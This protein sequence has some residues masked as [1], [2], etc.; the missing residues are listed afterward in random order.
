MRPLL[1]GV[2]TAQQRLAD[3]IERL[4]GMGH[5]LRVRLDEIVAQALRAAVRQA[6]VRAATDPEVIDQRLVAAQQ[7]RVSAR[8]P[9]PP[10]KKRE[11]CLPSRRP[12]E[13][14]IGRGLSQMLWRA[15]TSWLLAVLVAGTFVLL[16]HVMG[17][18]GT[19]LLLG[20]GG[21]ALTLL[22]LLLA[23]C[24]TVPQLTRH[25]RTD[26]E[27]PSGEGAGALPP[28][29]CRSLPSP[30]ARPRR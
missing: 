5:S 1:N 27:A 25:S 24:W 2:K 15:R 10:T 21:F 19:V 6:V 20:V 22:A 30:C 11:R 23:L 12:V 9:P 3:Q 8:E 17:P 7:D 28:C 29:F 18:V 4:D 26:P 14:V 16:G 13:G